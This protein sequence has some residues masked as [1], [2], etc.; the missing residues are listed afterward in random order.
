MVNIIHFTYYI[1]F[2]IN[3][4]TCQRKIHATAMIRNIL[5]TYAEATNSRNLNNLL[6]GCHRIHNLIGDG[7]TTLETISY[8]DSILI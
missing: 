2:N 3:I 1:L 7:S 4:H 5:W 8:V 6:R